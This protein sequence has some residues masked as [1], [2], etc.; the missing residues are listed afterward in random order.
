LLISKDNLFLDSCLIS[1]LCSDVSSGHY[2]L[3]V[4]DPLCA[5]AFQTSPAPGSRAGQLD[6]L[7]VYFP[8]GNYQA[9]G[10]NS[11]RGYRL[12]SNLPERIS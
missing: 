11:W 9:I 4:R 7:S 2:P 5:A 10:D 6:T 1:I 8:S 12:E 3:T